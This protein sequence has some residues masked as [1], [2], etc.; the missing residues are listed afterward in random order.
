MT[1]HQETHS[2]FAINLPISTMLFALA[3]ILAA[4]FVSV[5]SVE[6]QTIAVLHS[7]TAHDDGS[8]PIAGVTLDRAGNLYGTTS[9]SE[10]GGASTV[11]KLSH[12]GSGWVLNTLYTFNHAN[13]PTDVYAGVVLG[14]DGALYGTSYEGAQFNLGAVFVLRPP[15]TV[16]RSVSCPWTLTILHSFGGSD[17]THPDLGNL[18]FDSAGNIYGTTYAG[19]AH[20][21]GTVFKLTRSNGWAESVLYSFTG[22]S[23]GGSPSSGVAF[24]SAGNLYGT[25]TDGGS[26][27]Y[28]TVYQLSPSGS[29]WT[30]TTLYSFT[31]ND[32]GA[33][34]IG[35][36]ALDA[37]GNLYG[38]TSVA[39]GGRGAGTVWE[40]S[41]SGG[42][43]GFSVLHSF[44]GPAYPGPQATLTIDAA[45][46]IYGTSTFTG[47]GSGFGEAF[48]LTSSGGG[49]TYTSYEFDGITL[50][51][52]E[53]SV[54]VDAN[55][56]LYGTSLLGGTD[57]W[58]TVWE[59]T[60]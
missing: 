33:T 53:C 1:G 26:D 25:T 46:N 37:L 4:A 54:A 13:D 29:G 11:F 7:F 47:E 23:D 3:V 8:T 51:N 14:P 59:I 32:D 41:P 52:P 22:G 30:E 9:G 42:G 44:S 27:G 49:W 19:G 43:W 5:P 15:A 31:D 50:R 20:V 12:V 45:G 10:S 6:A 48:K 58:G 60:P 24:D 36:V 18:V 55:G 17:G 21:R 28:G 40:L 56:N 35:G 38:T 2:P 39:L 34:P 16:C 57:N